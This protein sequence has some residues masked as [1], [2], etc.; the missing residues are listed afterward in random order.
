MFN[1]KRENKA[2]GENHGLTKLTENQVN[3]IRN[4]K[5][6]LSQVKIARIFGV[7]KSTIGN[8]HNNI[9]WKIFDE[10]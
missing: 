10:N 6:K 1:K 2:K 8:I 5:S 7:S 3:H 4:L 9:T